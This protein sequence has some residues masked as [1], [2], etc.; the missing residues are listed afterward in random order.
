MALL[1]LEEDDVLEGAHHV[2]HII[3]LVQGDHLAR[4][5]VILT[6]LQ[7]GDLHD[8]THGIEDM[9]A[10][11][12]QLGLTPEAV[13]LQMAL[14]GLRVEDIEGAID[15]M[16]HF[17]DTATGTQRQEGLAILAAIQTNE[18]Q[19]AEHTLEE[20]L[21]VQGEEHTDEE[22]EHANDEG[23]EH[24]DEEEEHAD[25]EGEEHTDGEEGQA[26]E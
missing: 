24:T 16:N 21:G 18:F 6:Q 23:E 14:S 19:E 5:Q 26:D 25:D 9:L 20:L 22:E 8:A 11:T 1:S 7:E 13:H 3:K 12:A 17:L 10:G 2:E 4:M 15:H